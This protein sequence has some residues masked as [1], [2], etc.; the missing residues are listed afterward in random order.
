[1]QRRGVVQP[2][3]ISGPDEEPRGIRVED[4]VCGMPIDPSEAAG[5]AS[6]GERTVYFCSDHCRQIFADD[7]D[8]YL[9]RPE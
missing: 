3:R 5:S 8:R 7:P 4:P 2:D 9:E 6:A 1:M